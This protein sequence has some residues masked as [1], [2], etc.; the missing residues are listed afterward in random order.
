MKG[1]DPVVE[2]LDRIIKLLVLITTEEKSQR[3]RIQLLSAAG[4]GPSEIA[5]VLGT[6]ANTVHVALHSIRKQKRSS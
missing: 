2:R 6:T 3:E 1:K 4:L 5:E